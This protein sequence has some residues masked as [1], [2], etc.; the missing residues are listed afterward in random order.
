MDQRV[1][2]VASG[3]LGAAAARALE[4][5]GAAGQVVAT[6]EEAELAVRQGRL[7]V[8][9]ELEAVVNALGISVYRLREEDRRPEPLVLRHFEVRPGRTHPH[10]ARDLRRQE[11]GRGRGRP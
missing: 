2:V 1:I 5:A 4:Q 3:A 6:V 9:A 11:R 10:T 7:E 8:A